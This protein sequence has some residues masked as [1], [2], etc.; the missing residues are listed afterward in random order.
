MR[1]RVAVG[2]LVAAVLVAAQ[3]SAAEA[4]DRLTTISLRA[5]GSFRVV[6]H[7]DSAAGCEAAGMCGYSGS[8]TYSIAP[9]AELE[10]DRS[11]GF[12][13]FFGFLDPRRRAQVRVRREVA[14]GPAAECRDAF[15]DIGFTLEVS[16]A[17][18]DR[19]WL[20]VS[21]DF[22]PDPI[23]SGRCAG[24]HLSDFAGSLPSAAFRLPELKRRG[25]RV[26]LAG[27]FPFK[28]GPLT[29]EVVSTLRLRTR[30]VK[31]Q[32]VRSESGPPRH[33]ERLVFAQVRYR[34]VRAQGLVAADFRAV[35]PPMCRMLDACG[36][37]GGASYSVA[38]SRGS[39]ELFAVAPA[40][41][42]HVPKLRK[43]L[44]M[45]L[46]HG[47]LFGFGEIRG[48]PGTTT[49]TLVRPG[50]PTCTAH[51]GP[52]RPRLLFDRS[53]HRKLRIALGSTAG[54]AI[55]GGELDLLDGRCPG[56]TQEEISRSGV[57]ASA[58][59]SLASL[60]RR[61]LHAVLRG[62][63]TFAAGAYRG[64]R[65]SRVELDL[66]RTHASVQMGRGSSGS[67]IES[68]GFAVRSG[69]TTSAQRP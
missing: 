50:A 8:V 14:G 18:R 58:G 68:G 26:N 19:R 7:G 24:P 25:A 1:A 62:S 40:H 22:T 35:E 32:R 49:S 15:D 55:G 37:S 67:V 45:A 65:N 53:S 30:R 9:D 43:A 34:V 52:A 5:T 47:E 27:R 17:Y 51:E 57:A 4:D 39:F 20:S 2:L 61:A 12:T 13:D 6:W 59:I 3:A 66:E 54:N 56:P 23:A 48:D 44:E 46:R 16:R 28:A 21:T 38:S 42:R 41:G 36:T 63:G 29:G 11:G 10:V 64:T 31:T 60:T 69:A 33:T